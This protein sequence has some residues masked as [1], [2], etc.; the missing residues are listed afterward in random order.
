MR[1][2]LAILLLALLPLSV[3]LGGRERVTAPPLAMPLGQFMEQSQ[4]EIQT[5]LRRGQYQEITGEAE[6]EVL[7]ALQRMVEL[8]AG[9]Q[10]IHDLTAD[11]R[12][13]LL[14]DQELVNTRLTQAA[15]DSRLVCTRHQT[16]GT[17]LKKTHCMTVAERRELR[18]ESRSNLMR[19]HFMLPSMKPPS[20]DPRTRLGG[21]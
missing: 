11:E 15:E 10:D 4:A 6:A 1:T 5:D 13:R 9:K 14:T 19:S 8:T 2:I 3:A 17:H 7:A 12:A 18:D 20:E 21:R 16:V